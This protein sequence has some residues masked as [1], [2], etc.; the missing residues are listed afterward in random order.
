M[1]CQQIKFHTLQKRNQ[2]T[3]L[4]GPIPKQGGREL[5]PVLTNPEEIENR[6]STPQ[7]HQMFF[8]HTTPEEC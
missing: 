4:T 8:V 6:G 7:T 1:L 5:G 3:Q 2:L